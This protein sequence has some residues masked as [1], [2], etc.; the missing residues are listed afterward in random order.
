[1][2]VERVRRRREEGGRE[3]VIECVC[4]LV[5]ALLVKAV[6]ALELR[7]SGGGGERRVS[8]TRGHQMVRHIS[9]RREL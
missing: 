9:S 4:R 2:G 5:I 8:L 7:G 6:W 3:G 1:M